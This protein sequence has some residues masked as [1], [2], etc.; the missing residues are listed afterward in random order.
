MLEILII[1]HHDHAPLHRSTFSH[2]RTIPHKLN[3]YKPQQQSLQFNNPTLNPSSCLTQGMSLSTNSL[4]GQR[5]LS[6]QH[7][8]NNPTRRKG[9]TDKAAEGMKP[10]SQKSYMEKGQ[11]AATDAYDKV[12]GG[13]QGSGNKSA[14]Q[15][16]G[17]AAS[18]QNQKSYLEQAKD[19]TGMN[20]SKSYSSQEVRA[21]ADV[22]LRVSLR[23][24][25]S[26]HLIFIWVSFESRV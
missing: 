11:E 7:D 12:A 22:F 24:W 3:I 19:A 5:R 1:P 2:L 25:Q 16:A 10:D 6:A 15:Q 17:D 23:S 8:T 13:A 14:T 20:N 21:R 26:Y 9:M 4:L 18:G